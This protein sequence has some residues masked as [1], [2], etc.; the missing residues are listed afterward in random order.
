MQN[1]GFMVGDMSLVPHAQV[2]VETIRNNSETFKESNIFV[3]IP[4][5]KQIKLNI[6]NIHQIE[7]D[8]PQDFLSLPYADKMWAA[9]ALEK[10]LTGQGFIW[11]DVDSLILQEPHEFVL[12]SRKSIGYKAVDIRNIGIPA[13]EPLDDFWQTIYSHFYLDSTTTNPM[14]TTITQESIH[15]YINAGMIVLSHPRRLFATVTQAILDLH[16]H[17]VIEK[18]LKESNLHRIFFHQ[19]I[20]TVSILY[21]F[22]QNE[23]HYLS[24]YI[25]YPL[26][27]NDRLLLDLNLIQTV[28][29][30]MFFNENNLVLEAIQ[31][32]VSGREEE[33]KMSWYY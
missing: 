31:K 33:L 7:F 19:A 10:H 21:I 25:N 11:L 15:P 5:H 22:P 27:F 4:Q 12:P 2:L 18:K 26:Q 29:Y 30:D 17:P 8:L 28:R 3:L 24:P 14:K 20:L 16:K 6:E 32:I 13:D 23:I 9:A 1:I